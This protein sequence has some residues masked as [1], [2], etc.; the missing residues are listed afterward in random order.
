MVK[1]GLLAQCLQYNSIGSVSIL[2]DPFKHITSELKGKL[3]FLG[4]FKFNRVYLKMCQQK[5]RRVKNR[6]KEKW[7]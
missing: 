4:I 1:T 3:N 6:T 7:I 2:K 5:K